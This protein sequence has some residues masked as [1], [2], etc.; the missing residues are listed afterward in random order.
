MSYQKGKM[1]LAR[2]AEFLETNIVDLAEDV[3]SVEVGLDALDT[4]EVPVT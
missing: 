3:S 1:G 4:T 2:L